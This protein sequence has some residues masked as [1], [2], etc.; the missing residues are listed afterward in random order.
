MRALSNKMMQYMDR[1][2]YIIHTL[3]SIGF[4]DSMYLSYA[5]F[6]DS[7]LSCS[8]LNG[9]NAVAASPYA[10]FL[11][12]PLAYLGVLYYLSIVALACTR[13]WQELFVLT[14]LGALMSL[15]F[16]YL[17]AFV[18]GAFCVYCLT[19]AALSFILPLLV[20]VNYIRSHGA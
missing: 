18:I 13:R 17:Q 8:I 12:V 3:A 7:Q 2:R 20:Y 5:R 9:C 15:Y 19:S 10:V 14:L 11:G 1:M 16:I 4:V 6:T